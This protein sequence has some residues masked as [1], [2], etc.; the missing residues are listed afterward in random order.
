MNETH[1]TMARKIVAAMTTESWKTIPHAVITYDPDVTRVLLK[2]KQI[3]ERLD[4]NDRITI[5]TLILK[6]I[7]EGLKA[8]PKMNS[9]FFYNN[10]LVRGCLKQLE[11]IDISLPVVLA[12]GEMMTLNIHNIG[13]QSLDEINRTISD[14]RRRADQSILEEAFYEVS[15]DNT[16]QLVKKGHIVKVFGRIIGLKTGKHKIEFLKGDEKKKYYSISSHDRLTKHD[17]EQGSITVSNLGSL[18]RDWIGKCT[19]LEIIPPQVS[20][21]G[22]GAVAKVPMVDEYD[23]IKVGKTLPMTIAFDHRAL[24]FGDVIPFMEKLDDIFRNP[25]IIDEWIALPEINKIEKAS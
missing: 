4:E 2:L 10:F 25:D 21:I 9:H 23:N 5:N 19:M 15:M 16:V 17:I 8:C 7:S 1:F 22:L 3:N 11:H 20:A 24:D 6:I 12:S 13:E 18:K 14:V